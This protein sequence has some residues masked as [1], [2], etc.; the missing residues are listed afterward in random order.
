MV[1]ENASA[2]TTSCLENP[3]AKLLPEQNMLEEMMHT[4]PFISFEPV[5]LGVLESSEECDSEDSL[6][7]H[8]DE[9]SSSSLTEFEPLPV[10]LEYVVLD[11]NR[12][13]TSSFHDASLEMENQW[14]MEFCEALTL[15]SNEKDSTNEH[16]SFTF[17]IPRK[18]CSFNATPESG[19]ISAPCT[20]E[21]YNQ[22]KVLFCKIFRRLVVDVYVYRKHCRFRACTVELI[23]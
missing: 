14:A 8:E 13:S 5:L 12:E 4:S 15:E 7:S 19:M 10:G 9:R 21:D 18:P 11:H 1:R 20:H 22:L 23:L 6:H 16:G 3:L 17:D 2:T